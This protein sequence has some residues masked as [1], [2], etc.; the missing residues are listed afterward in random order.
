M[1]IRIANNIFRQLSLKKEKT[2]KLALGTMICY[3]KDA[4]IRIFSKKIFAKKINRYEKRLFVD[5]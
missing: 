3:R 5:I 4:Y 1:T 2:L